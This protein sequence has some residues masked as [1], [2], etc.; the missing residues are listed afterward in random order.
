MEKSVEKYKQVFPER[1]LPRWINIA[2]AFSYILGLL[3]DE[4][5]K[6]CFIQ[7]GQVDI[8]LLLEEYDVPDYCEMLAM[9]FNSNIDA[10]EEKEFLLRAHT[11]L[12]NK[13]SKGD[14]KCQG[15]IQETFR[16]ALTSCHPPD[17]FFLGKDET[18]PPSDF[19]DINQAD[20]NDKTCLNYKT[21]S[22]L[23]WEEDPGD[24][25]EY[26][27]P[28][29]SAAFFING[30]SPGD[31][32]CWKVEWVNLQVK[33]EDL[34][35]STEYLFNKYF[36]RDNSRTLDH[37]LWSRVMDPTGDN[38]FFFSK[39]TNSWIIEFDD[40]T[41]SFYPRNK[42]SKKARTIQYLL[43]NGGKKIDF[44]T[45]WCNWCFL[46]VLKAVHTLPSEENSSLDNN[47]NPEGRNQSS[48][49][50]D[51][52]EL[53]GFEKHEIKNISTQNMPLRGYKA[54]ND[55][56]IKKFRVELLK[57]EEKIKNADK[58]EKK[59]KLKEDLN[60][61]KKHFLS[62]F[63][64]GNLKNIDDDLDKIK[65]RVRKRRDDFKK[66]LKAEFEEK[67]DNGEV[68][69]ETPGPHKDFYY[70]LHKN[71]ENIE[72]GFAY[73]CNEKWITEE[74]ITRS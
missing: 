21:Q 30:Y 2:A 37:E 62:H 43:Q 17:E 74:K 9:S 19:M 33:T 15:Q 27:D 42:T 25:E 44:A 72:V 50:A 71:I 67:D 66:D 14:I 68:I 53:K 24:I 7:K 70:H 41:F 16:V 18:D 26:G 22:A 5:D 23:Q 3:Q 13:L 69:K 63:Y 39:I 6:K 40:E 45:K 49:R 34:I 61:L 55:D 73:M 4:S 54:L 59:K 28:D 1:E 35:R 64:K 38:R 48:I 46:D 10:S 31:A 11:L 47:Q 20:W 32:F 8:T 60:F 36:D 29:S 58:K 12:I 57:I 52:F 56:D 51:E 65:K